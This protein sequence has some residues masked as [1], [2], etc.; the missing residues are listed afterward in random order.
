MLDRPLDA[1]RCDLAPSCRGFS[2]SIEG[3]YCAPDK[4]GSGGGH[5]CCVE[6]EWTPG[7][8]PCK[9]GYGWDYGDGYDGLC[10][11]CGDDASIWDPSLWEDG[12]CKCVDGRTGPN[13]ELVE[14][15]ADADA[16]ARVSPARS[17]VA[18]HARVLS[19]NGPSRASQP[20]SATDR[21]GARIIHRASTRP[22]GDGGRRHGGAFG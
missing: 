16:V 20:R 13:C 1:G 10:K 6:G 11:K 19:R 7:T 2:C 12:E 8:C 14:C 22:G 3:Q 15:A 9:D 21:R 18:A 17:A 5:W 4:S